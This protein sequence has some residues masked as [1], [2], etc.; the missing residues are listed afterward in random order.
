MQDFG[1]SPL[2]L[3]SKLR[4]MTVSYLHCWIFTGSKHYIQV[5][6]LLSW[7]L[8]PTRTSCTFSLSHSPSAEKFVSSNYFFHHC[9]HF[10]LTLDF[11]RSLNLVLLNLS[12]KTSFTSVG[13]STT[14][15]PLC[16]Q[17]HK[18]S[19]LCDQTFTIFKWR[20]TDTRHLAP[21]GQ[22]I[23]VLCS[24]SDAKPVVL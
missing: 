20:E 2:I 9:E 6:S 12:C 19:R 21:L 8:L 13:L 3:T 22:S 5:F 24:G 11:S 17:C 7:W 14:V 15:I 23:A 1:N 10:S 4:E 16:L 18:K